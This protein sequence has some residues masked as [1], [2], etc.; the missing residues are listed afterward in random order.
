MVIYKKRTTRKVVKGKRMKRSMGTRR[1]NNKKKSKGRRT[2]RGGGLKGPRPA[3]ILQPTAADRA[4]NAMAA[5]STAVALDRRGQDGL[6]QGQDGLLQGQLPSPSADDRRER[7]QSVVAR[8]EA[9]L[10]QANARREEQAQ[11]PPS[12]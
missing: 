10:Q 9:G 3:P 1:K 8:V 6:P 7:I 5:P 4:R 2:R 12:P 11:M